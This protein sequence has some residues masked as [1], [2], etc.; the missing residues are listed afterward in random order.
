M[1]ICG[2]VLINHEWI[3][4]AAHCLRSETGRYPISG[5]RV[6]LG[7]IYA[8]EGGE[9]MRVRNTILHEVIDVLLPMFYRFNLSKEA[10]HKIIASKLLKSHI[11]AIL[12]FYYNMFMLMR[13]AIL[14]IA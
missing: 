12:H 13:N 6:R 10:S 11:A 5:I 4:T 3:L 9:Y 7:S 1:F 2:G 14:H 8:S